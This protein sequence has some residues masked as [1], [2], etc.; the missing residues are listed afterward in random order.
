MLKM[1]EIHHL[2]P[3]CG[4]FHHFCVNYTAIYGTL[5][6]KMHKKITTRV[7]FYTLL[8]LKKYQPLYVVVGIR[9]NIRLSIF[10]IQR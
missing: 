4:I 7:L 10:L 1:L 2:T 5:Q 9:T 3:L 6:V 8:W